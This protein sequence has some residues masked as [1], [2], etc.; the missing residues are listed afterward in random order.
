MNNHDGI[1]PSPQH[2]VQHIPALRPVRGAARCAVGALLLAALAWVARAVWEIRLAMAGEPA[3]GPPDQGEGVHRPLTALEDSYH[4]VTTLGGVAALVCAFAFLSWLW[5]VRD[6]GTDLSGAAPRYAGYW[7]YLGWIVPFMNLW[8]P[9]GL[10][11]DVWQATAPGRRAPLSLNVWWGLWLVGLLSGVGL[12]YTD[13]KDEVIERAYTEPWPLLA[14]DAAIVGAAVAAVFLVRAVT[15]AQ[16]ER[17][18]QD[19][20]GRIPVAATS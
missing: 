6:N 20:D 18:R 10:V 12:L 7:V 3:S 11:A 2:P 15:A 9:R 13:S 16:S 17:A 4:Q 1:G 5:R 8:V 19:P 14:S